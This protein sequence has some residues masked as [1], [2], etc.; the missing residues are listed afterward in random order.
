MNDAQALARSVTCLL[1]NAT[2][3]ATWGDFQTDWDPIIT[4]LTCK[5]LLSCGLTPQTTWCINRGG[6]A[7]CTLS[8]SFKWLNNSIRP[9]GTFGTDFWDAAQLAI[10][11]EK[12]SLHQRF[13]AYESL[14]QHLGKV[15]Q[16]RA[17]TKDPSEWQGPGS[18]AAAIE[19]TRLLGHERE[20]GL[21]TKEMLGLQLHG[22]WQGHS[23]L[24]NSPLGVWH[25]AQCIA[26]LATDSVPHREA[27]AKGIAWLKRAQHE[28]GAWKSIQQYNI[29]FTSYAILALLHEQR[30]DSPTG[31]SHMRKALE[32]LKS[33]IA[34]DGKCS[35]LGGTLMCA[36]AFRAVVGETFEKDLTLVDYLLAK[37][38]LQRADAAD[39]AMRSN[40]S[41]LSRVRTELER[42]EKKYADADFVV[43][44]KQ[45]LFLA[46]LALFITVFGTIT[47]VYG[48][49]YALR[50]PITAP[51]PVKE[52]TAR[53]S[54]EVGPA[55]QTPP[56][57]E[58]EEEARPVQ[59]TPA[60]HGKGKEPPPPPQKS[61]SESPK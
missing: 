43:T 42:Y 14:K 38:N 44:K 54:V 55:P 60:K 49:N 32:Y 56:K 1:E 20:A 40:E 31:L 23:G 58:K 50:T 21:L 2:S 12:F 33:Q 28:S 24:N 10:V 6:Y 22:S 41:E 27:I 4:A 9:D 5:L 52:E 61:T 15:I 11:I 45:L 18:F 19:F 16:A 25:T 46:L 8:D 36:M 7:Y 35:D 26:V 13:T 53:P 30:Q 57:K 34:N 37:K 48:L 39:A 51:P 17:F 47:G 29:Y 59:A 3:Q